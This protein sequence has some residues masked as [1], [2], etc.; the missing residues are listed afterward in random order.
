MAVENAAKPA[1][2]RRAACPP[3]KMKQIGDFQYLVPDVTERSL[4]NQ[5]MT[6][7]YNIW[8]SLGGFLGRGVQNVFFGKIS[9][10]ILLFLCY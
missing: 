4:L 5:R 7:F 2:P 10:L 9:I 1:H 6:I 3:A 8:L